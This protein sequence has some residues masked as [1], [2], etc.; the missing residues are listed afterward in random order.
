MENLQKR[1]ADAPIKVSQ[2][3]VLLTGYT[4][5]IR[6]SGDRPIPE[7]YHEQLSEIVEFF[8]TWEK[9]WCKKHV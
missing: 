8:E 3:S 2:I 9:K 5:N 6:T 4:T 1:L 7:R